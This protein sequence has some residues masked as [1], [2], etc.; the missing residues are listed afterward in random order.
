MVPE[1]THQKI[2]VCEIGYVLER[3]AVAGQKAGDQQRQGRVFGA[4]NLNVAVEPLPAGDLDAI[5][6]VCLP[7]LRPLRGPWRGLARGW[8]C[9]PIRRVLRHE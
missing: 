2:D 1:N 8:V 4:R 9:Q 7:H 5:H 6:G 3:Q